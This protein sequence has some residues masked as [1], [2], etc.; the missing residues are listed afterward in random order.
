MTTLYHFAANVT[1]PTF[2][3]GLVAPPLPSPVLGVD[4]LRTFYHP[5]T[6]ADLDA[7]TARS[8]ADAIR[9]ETESY[10]ARLVEADI[11]AEL[12]R[13]AEEAELAARYDSRCA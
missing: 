6:A 9:E 13:L 3:L 5:A 12:E 4:D 11:E 10:Y 2:G 7:E 1:P 8:I